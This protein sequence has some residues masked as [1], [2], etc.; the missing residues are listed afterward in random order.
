MDLGSLSFVYVNAEGKA[1]TDF[2]IQVLL[3]SVRKRLGT[4]WLFI[5]I[6]EA[7]YRS[8]LD[9]ETAWVGNHY[10][11]RFP[12]AGGRAAK[13]IWNVKCEDFSRGIVRAGR[14]FRV[15]LDFSQAVAATM[16]PY[17]KASVVISHLAHGDEWWGSFDDL[18]SLLTLAPRENQKFVVGDMNVEGRTPK[19]DD[20]NKDKWAHL[21]AAMDAMNLG[22][23]LPMDESLVTRRPKGLAALMADPSYIDHCFFP[24]TAHAS[25]D[26]VWDEVIGDHAW[27]DVVLHISDRRVRRK[28]TTWKCLD[29][30]AYREDVIQSLPE[31]FNSSEHFEVF[32]ADKMEAHKSPLSARQRRKY[33]EPFAIKNLRARI[34]N[35]TDEVTRVTLSQRLFKER[36]AWAKN[37]DV[38][39]KEQ[40]LKQKRHRGVKRQM[41]VPL[42]E[43]LIDDTPQVDPTLWASEAETDFQSR[44]RQDKQADLALFEALDGSLPASMVVYDSDV[45]RAIDQLKKPWALDRAG[46]CA[47]AL[48]LVPEVAQ[49]VASLASLL[50][51]SDDEW[52]HV[53]VEGFVKGKERGLIPM[54][55]TRGLLPQTVLLNILNRIV[56]GRISPHLDAAS[57]R[58]GV[59]NIIL[60]G[61]KGSQP[62]DITFATAQV[63]EKGRDR[64]N[65]GAVAQSDIEKFHDRVPWGFTLKGLLSRQVPEAWARAALRLHRCPR[66][67]LRVGSVSTRT[68]ERTRSVLTGSPSAGMLARISVED[69][70]LAAETEM[71]PY[72]FKVDDTHRLVAMSWSDNLFTFSDTMSN[73]CEMM[74]IW[75]HHFNVLCGLTLKPGSHETIQSSTR[76]YEHTQFLSSGVAWKAVSSMLSLG[77]CLTSTGD[78][79]E[80]RKRVRRSWEAAF[81]RNARILTCT[82]IGV[83]SRLQFWGSLSRGIGGFR[84]CMWTPSRTASKIVEG[85]HNLILQRI[86]RVAFEEGESRERFC[87]RRNQVVACHR[88]QFRLAVSLEWSLS[89]VRWVEHLHRHPDLP[90]AVLLTVQDDTWMQIARGVNWTPSQDGSLR[91]GST[92]TRAGPGKP[93]RWAENWLDALRAEHGLDNAARS[94]K[95]TKRRAAFLRISLI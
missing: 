58:L 47:A 26:I 24:I 78:Q 73:A 1:N 60:G 39:A 72:G 45:W 75:S 69:T 43:I 5:A 41:L 77:Q 10:V 18:N 22:P 8:A 20:D 63:L 16:K 89:L 27:I 85:W 15:E 3:E 7:D 66:V 50:L 23:G 51:S 44:W 38:L 76:R 35:S 19:Q 31:T 14:S 9:L 13:L 30:H 59:K 79:S 4:S 56:M 84:Y 70:F 57:E 49:P 54:S 53:V 67:H 32:F 91:A 93:I 55:K 62:Q 74:S 65:A 37:R 87:R 40:D 95:T 29:L 90:S 34:R 33:W 83:A 36:V 80:D 82:K 6:S 88:E 52:E 11:Q 12:I 68:L 46:V 64:M 48:R 92:R 25:G 42:T 86:V 2:Q 61:G 21:I 71:E 81:W 94:R 17:A 28:P